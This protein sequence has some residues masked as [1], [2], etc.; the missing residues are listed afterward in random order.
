M[1][2]FTL[3]WLK[4]RTIR[5]LRRKIQKSLS[6]R[7]LFGTLEF[8]I[9]KFTYYIRECAPSQRRIRQQKS[10]FDQRFGIDTSGTIP[11]SNLDIG[12]ENWMDGERYQATDPEL[13]NEMLHSVQV[14]YEDFVFVDL[15]SGKGITLLLASEFPFKRVIG[16][17]FSPELHQIAQE[18]IR[19][20]KSPTQKCR[21]L[22]SICMDVV[23][24]P[25][26]K[27]R[28]IF[29]LYNPFG[30]KIMVSVLNNIERSLD[31]YPR[32]IIII[33]HDPVFGVLLDTVEFLERIKRQR[34]YSI[35]VNKN[36]PVL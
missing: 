18:N 8:C 1:N 23:I 35:Y 7:G 36:S 12:S 16:V 27:E 14:K 9:R 10:E 20:Y 6:R 11:L 17:E 32:E 28:A 13:F 22:E 3:D 26:P 4:S 21:D 2:V 25:I 30:E 24:Y 31:D 19:I 15:G 34:D 33:Y 5:S 29:Y